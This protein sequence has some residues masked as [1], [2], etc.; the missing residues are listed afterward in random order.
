MAAPVDERLA[1]LRM[2]E[3]EEE[4]GWHAAMGTAKAESREKVGTPKVLMRRASST[5]PESEEPRQTQPSSAPKSSVDRERD[6]AAARARIFG[7]PTSQS[8]DKRNWAQQALSSVVVAR[9][10]GDGIGFDSRRKDDKSL[11]RNRS[12]E[13][14]DPDFNRDNFVRPQFA[15][16]QYYP[17]ARPYY[18]YPYYGYYGPPP[19]PPGPPP[20]PLQPPPPREPYPYYPNNS[21]HYARPPTFV[22]RAQLQHHLPQQHQQPTLRGGGGG[23]GGGGSGGGPQRTKSPPHGGRKPRKSPEHRSNARS[24]EEEFPSLG[25]SS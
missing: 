19:P 22:P 11:W 18:D 13:L 7:K 21:G 16:R 23:G 5:P 12:V 24:Y 2:E 25:G 17:P 1:A 4:E 10:P 8:A 20:P 14:S 9:G 3:D 15:P 6:Y